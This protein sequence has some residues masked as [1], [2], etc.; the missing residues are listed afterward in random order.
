[1]NDHNYSLQE[2]KEE[3]LKEIAELEEAD[4]SW[5]NCRVCP[6]KGK[7]CLDNDIDIRE[8]EWE[9]IKTLLDKDSS[10]REQ[11]YQNLLSHSRCYFHSEKC[12][13]IAPIRPTNCLYTPYQLI[14]NVYD[15]S[16]EYSLRSPSCDFETREEKEDSLLPLSPYLI[17]KG[18]H[19]YL[20]LNYWFL[21]YENQS[22]GTY[23]ETGEERLKE[24]FHIED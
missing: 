17:Q 18:E 21:N 8:D 15:K 22:E 5:K 11:V 20:F 1:M 16:I 7:C 6:F 13:L 24:Y 19:T 12:C 9:E 4:P 14:Q 3:L 2:I 10:I 23:K